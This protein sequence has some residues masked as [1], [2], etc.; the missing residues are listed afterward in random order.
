[1]RSRCRRTF[2]LA[3]GPEVPPNPGN[4][5]SY[6]VGIMPLLWPQI[7]SLDKFHDH[8][9]W[10]CLEGKRNDRA[11][12]ASLRFTSARHWRPRNIS[13]NRRARDFTLAVRGL[14]RRL[15]YLVMYGPEIM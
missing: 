12:L 4:R 5:V 8:L 2:A 7:S 14:L 3:R 13:A 1:M 6:D 10:A 15:G 9:A 11:H